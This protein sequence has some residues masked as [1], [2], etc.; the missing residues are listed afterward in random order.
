MSVKVELQVERQ[1]GAELRMAEVTVLGD[2]GVAGTTAH[3]H[4]SASLELSA[5]RA[6]RLLLKLS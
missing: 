1:E 6:G 3:L 2:S 4:Y 5:A